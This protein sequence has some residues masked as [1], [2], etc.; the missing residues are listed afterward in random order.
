M[1]NVEEKKNGWCITY[2]P[3]DWSTREDKI[4]S[5]W[6]LSSTLPLSNHISYMCLEDQTISKTRYTMAPSGDKLHSLSPCHTLSWDI[7][8]VWNKLVLRNDRYPI[9]QSCISYFVY[10]S[11]SI[12]RGLLCHMWPDKVQTRRILEYHFWPCNTILYVHQLYMMFM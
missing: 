6:Y 3:S 4:P 9:K 11:N 1:C 10:I 12:L 8:A 2:H 7:H 5:E